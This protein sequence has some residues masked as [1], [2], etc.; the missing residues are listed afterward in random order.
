V[1]GSHEHSDEPSGSGTMELVTYYRALMLRFNDTKPTGPHVCCD[2]QLT[3][4]NVDISMYILYTH[5]TST[6]F[7][8]GHIK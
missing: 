3:K 2:I 7:H 1:V 4:A 8:L 5:I 6:L